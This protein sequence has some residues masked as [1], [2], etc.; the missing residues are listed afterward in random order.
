LWSRSE[1]L[2][3]FH[4]FLRRGSSGGSGGE[5]DL[6]EEEGQGGHEIEEMYK[7]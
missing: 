1:P 7:Q 3:K 6:D 4:A 5:V 2:E